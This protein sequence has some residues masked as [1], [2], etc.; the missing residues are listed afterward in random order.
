MQ[1]ELSSQRR[2]ELKALAHGLRPVVLIGAEGLSAN[3]MSEID[4]SLKAH[5][6]I[7]VRVFVGERRERS[8]FMEAV[9]AQTGALP[10]Q[11]IGRILVVYRKNPEK[12]AAS[13]RAVPAATNGRRFA[14][15][16]R[17]KVENGRP[18]KA[19][20]PRRVAAPDRTSSEPK[21]RRGK[22]RPL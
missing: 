11:H 2:R 17:R 6:L 22:R 20:L 8:A 4:R 21:R 19:R 13:N 1:N 5:E 12:S 14:A 10:V 3:V 16:D 18:G 7:K 9:C 15:R